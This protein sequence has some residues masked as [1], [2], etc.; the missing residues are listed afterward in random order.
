MK[1]RQ[2]KFAIEVFDDSQASR[3]SSQ[4]VQAYEYLIL[5]HLPR[6]DSRGIS[7]KLV[8]KIVKLTIVLGSHVWTK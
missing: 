6:C 4:R 2:R 3:V 5:Q 8:R 7:W 1:E